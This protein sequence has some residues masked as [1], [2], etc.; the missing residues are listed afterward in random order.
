M[1]VSAPAGVHDDVYAGG[2]WVPSSSTARIGVVDP[3][4]EELY[5]WVPD[6]G[7]GDIDRAVSAARAAFPRWSV[8]PVAERAAVLRAFADEL[9]RRGEWLSATLTRENGS[10]VAETGGMGAQAAAQ[11]RYYAGLAAAIE[12]EVRPFPHGPMESVV[13]KLPVGV[14]GLITP[15]NYPLALA[16]TKLAPALMAG[17]TTVIKPAPETPL[18]IRP[19]VEAA[20]VAG[21][22]AGVIN[23]V[24]GGG[25]T[26]A[27]LVEH[28][29]V[30]KIAFTGSTVTG[31]LIGEHCGRLLRPLTLELGGKSAAVLLDDADLDSF[32]KSVVRLTMRNTGQTCY[33]CSRVLAPAPRYD[34]IVDLIIDAV[35]AAPIGDPFDPATVFGPVVSARQRERIGGYVEIGQQEG[36]RLMLG[37]GRPAGLDRG[38][39]V[40]PAVFRDVTPDMRIAQ[41]EI[42]GPVL[43]VLSYTDVDDAIR[44][45]NHSRYGLAGAVFSA[46][47]DRAQ[48]VA[49]RIETGNVGINF[50]SSNYAAPF[51]GRKDSGIGV[52]FGPEGLASYQMFQ[53]VHRRKAS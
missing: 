48:E 53:S 28:P 25:E 23:A 18:H 10:P 4:T 22:P 42:F 27:M 33:V 29:G 17:C 34:E 15:W 45:A 51:A 31:R 13:R 9:E 46:D 37:G 20:T 24:T 36:G 6:G 16:M 43:C 7:A 32:A 52:E 38:W 26:G 21:V 19:L 1:T 39:F 2:R 14:A 5:A 41:E 49:R 47:E 50:Y 8:T 30:D 12:D 35:R 44:I 3:A 11:L 40:N